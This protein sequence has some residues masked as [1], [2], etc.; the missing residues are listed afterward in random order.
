RQER[1]A[2][3]GDPLRRGRVGEEQPVEPARRV[4]VAQVRRRELPVHGHERVAVLGERERETIGD[5]LPAPR[6]R[7]PERQREQLER[8]REEKDERRDGRVARVLD[9]RP[10]DER[11]RR[12]AEHPEYRRL[13]DVLLAAVAEL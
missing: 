3:R 4:E 6:E 12:R 7:G 11:P 2:G 10:D 1:S 5:P 8:G 13:R 9:E